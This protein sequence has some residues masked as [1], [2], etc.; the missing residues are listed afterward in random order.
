[1]PTVVWRG[2]RNPSVAAWF[3]RRV[4][5]MQSENRYPCLYTATIPPRYVLG[6]FHDCHEAEVVINPYG[7]RGRLDSNS[8]IYA[9]DD[10]VIQLAAQWTRS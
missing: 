10:R 3:A 6:M 1:M 4:L 8:A 7:L 5:L 9:E 2:R